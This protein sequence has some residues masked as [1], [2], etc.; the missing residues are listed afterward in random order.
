MST[1]RIDLHTHTDES[2]GSLSPSELVSAAAAIGLCALAITDH[3]TFAGY[4]RAAAHAAEAGLDLI[5]GVELSTKYRGRSVHLLGYFVKGSPRAE[6]R[7]WILELQ[8]SRHSRNRRLVNALT[9]LGIPI[10]T[11]EL[12]ERGGKLPGRPHIASILVKKGFASSIQQ[13]FDQYLSESGACFMARDEPPLSEAIER[14]TAG[15]GLA[16]LAHPGRISADQEMLAGLLEEMRKAG[17]TGI[18]AYHSDHSQD[19]VARY[20]FLAERFSLAVTGGS[21]FHGALKPEIALGT[22]IAENLCVP[23]SVLE[24]LRRR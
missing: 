21:D 6:F 14:V 17:L 24:N 11:E 13:A 15:G 9:G 7:D 23:P 8:Q 3:D 22:G 1:P 16:S 10:T 20:T 2:D 12:H 5:C 4:D 19:D 18:E